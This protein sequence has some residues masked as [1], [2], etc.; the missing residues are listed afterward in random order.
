MNSK[1]SS[2]GST[3]SCTILFHVLRVAEKKKQQEKEI[4]DQKVLDLQ[5]KLEEKR[6]GL[7]YTWCHKNTR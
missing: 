5:Q 7:S 6:A 4:K 3:V 2:E 1:P